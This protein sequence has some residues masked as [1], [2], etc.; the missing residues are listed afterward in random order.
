MRVDHRRLH[1]AM[2]QKLLH[3]PNVLP[4][5]QQVRRE[6]VPQRVTGRRL[7]QAG[8]AHRVPKSAL[9]CSLGETQGIPSPEG[10]R[11]RPR[12]R[13]RRPSPLPRGLRPWPDWRPFRAWGVL[14]CS[15]TR[16]DARG[17]VPPPS[18]A[19]MC[20]RGWAEAQ[21]LC[22]RPFRGF[23]VTMCTGDIEV[24]GIRVQS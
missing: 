11:R 14:L 1:A 6:R 19:E 23:R 2:T 12:A 3:R 13:A 15:R 9:D 10:R 7:G 24:A 20:I 22:L 5:H 17:Y 16:A 8:P 4:I 18:G 21:A